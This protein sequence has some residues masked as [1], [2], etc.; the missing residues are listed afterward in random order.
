MLVECAGYWLLA[1]WLFDLEVVLC[2][3]LVH[4]T[5]GMTGAA[6]AAAAITLTS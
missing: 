1:A 3:Q 6:A 2:H 5:V 4:H